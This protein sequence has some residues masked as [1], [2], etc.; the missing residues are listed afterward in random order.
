MSYTYTVL[1]EE[2]IRLLDRYNPALDKVKLSELIDNA[3][4]IVASE[5]PAGSITA[6]KLATDAVET[7]KIK[8][9]NVTSGKLA[10][11]AVTKDKL[12]VG[13]KPSHMVVYAGE[14]TTVGT[15]ATESITV[16]GALATD[17]A[18]VVMKT[19]GA[20]PVTLL[21]AAANTDAVD[22]KFSADPSNDHVVSYL[23]IRATS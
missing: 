6:A 17:I 1:T 14:H 11:G 23:V 18:V 20:A 4:N 7:L 12:A 10:L 22:L 21:T 3:L 16:A 8:D 2:Q 9:L 13:V 5:I 19:E 15:S